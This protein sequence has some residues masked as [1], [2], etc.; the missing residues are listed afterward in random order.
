MTDESNS[1]F[2]IYQHDSRELQSRLKKEFD[3]IDGLVDTI[4]TSPPYADLIDYGDHDEQVGQ[5][6]Y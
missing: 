4:I 6:N 2:G 1:P 5:Q 3:N